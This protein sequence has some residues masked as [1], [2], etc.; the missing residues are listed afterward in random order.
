MAG[1]RL[2]PERRGTLEPLASSHQRV[3]EQMLARSLGFQPKPAR[4]PP[5]LN[6]TPYLGTNLGEFAILCRRFTIAAL[7][8]IGEV[9]DS[10]LRQA[11]L[12]EV[13]LGID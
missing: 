10:M 8:L 6:P 9:R 13:K 5:R 12:S 7:L 11:I 4:R 1:P 2:T 3:N